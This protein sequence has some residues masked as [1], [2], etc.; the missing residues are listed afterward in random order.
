MGL[1]EHDVGGHFA[2]DGPLL[3]REDDDLIARGCV[4]GASCRDENV[5]GVRAIRDDGS[6]LF[7]AE[8]VSLAF[9]RARAVAHVAADA[10]FGG[11][12]R[13]EALIAD[14][15]AL[16]V[17]EDRGRPMPHDARHLDLVHREDHRGG[18]AVLAERSAD[19]RQLTE[20]AAIAPELPGHVTR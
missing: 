4:G 20:R 10:L 19:P 8:P 15:R 2:L 16:V 18:A 7:E 12:R 11:R 5:V 3:A 17:G 6:A 9:D 13:D 1:L 14:E